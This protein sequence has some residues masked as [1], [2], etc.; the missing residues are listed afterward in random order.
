MHYVYILRCADECLYVGE[1]VDPDRRLV[2]H[3][4]GSACAFRAQRHDLA[5]LQPRLGPRKAPR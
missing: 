1:T 3:Q 5:A 2:E 4:E